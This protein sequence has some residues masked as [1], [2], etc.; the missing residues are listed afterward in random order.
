MGL[1]IPSASRMGNIIVNPSGVSP[2]ATE[3]YLRGPAWWVLDL[4]PLDNVALR[5]ESTLIPHAAGR[6]PNP[7][8]VDEGTY[9]MP[10]VIV[11]D[12]DRAGNATASDGLIQLQSN[13]DWLLAHVMG[14]LDGITETRQVKRTRAGGASSTKPAEIHLEIVKQ[15]GAIYD[16]VLTLTV[17]AGR[18]T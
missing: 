12:S 7:L 4:S 2:T 10:F 15:R 6:D 16:V 9:V 18:W 11:G 8:I 13:W 14:P 3:T 5:G 17:P 1:P